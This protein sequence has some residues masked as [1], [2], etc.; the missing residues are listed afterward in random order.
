MDAL[1][2]MVE[3]ELKKPFLV[4]IETLSRMGV[5]VLKR[6][7]LYQS[8][9]LLHKRGKYYIA[10]FKSLFA[11]DGKYSSFD[12]EDAQRRDTIVQVLVNWGFVGVIDKKK[13]FKEIDMSLIHIL[14]YS[15]KEDWILE[16]KHH[17]VKNN[18]E[19]NYNY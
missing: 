8:C 6:K 19:K 15:Q 4:I 3:V 1:K 7:T 16:A 9:H 12:E 17:I 18:N 2:E 10:H 11:L 13:V 5:P 14:P